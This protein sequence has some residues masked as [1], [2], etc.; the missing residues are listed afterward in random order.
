MP[1]RLLQSIIPWM[2]FFVCF[3]YDEMMLKVGAI[4]ALLALVLLDR[5]GLKRGFLFDWGSLLF[6]IFIF[7]TVIVFY[8]PWIAS[9]ALFLANCALTVIAW[10]SLLVNKPFIREYVK[11]IVPKEYWQTHI[12]KNLSY[13]L[14]VMWAFVFTLMTGFEYVEIKHFGDVSWIGEVVS[15]IALALAVWITSWF[16]QWYKVREMGRGGLINLKGLSA[17]QLVTTDSAVISY[18]TIGHGPSLLLLPAAQMTLYTWDVDFIENLAQRFQVILVDYP[19]INESVMHSGQF[20]V[21]GLTKVFAEFIAALQLKN[22][23]LV[24]YSM[25]GWIAQWLAIYYSDRMTNLVLIATDAGGSRA[26]PT[27]VVL[28]EQLVKEMPDEQRYEL[29][30]GN[31]FSDKASPIMMPKLTAIV[32]ASGSLGRVPLAILNQEYRLAQEWLD[33]SGSYKLL[34]RI[35]MPT[36]VI[37]GILD[38]VVHRQNALV[39]ANS[40]PGAKLT[41]YSD[42]A[43]GIIFQYPS[44]LA[45]EIIQLLIHK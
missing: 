26:T 35:Q 13:W 29:L 7:V 41:E 5:Q 19:G 3:G 8:Q 2:I 39:L 42:A 32:R 45:A 28:L 18:R 44:E 25:G 23:T 14:T 15:L 9:N 27:A 40:I 10:S 1:K 20:T 34:S 37:T 33:G 21:E 11:L 24:G 6:F 16:P 31:L 30:T 36:L 12:F 38:K 22:I 17:V 43:H 4:G